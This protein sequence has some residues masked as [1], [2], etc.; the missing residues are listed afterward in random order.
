M[1]STWGGDGGDTINQEEFE[2]VG[3]DKAMEYCKRYCWCH[4]FGYRLKLEKVVKD[5]LSDLDAEDRYS[6]LINGRWIFE[7]ERG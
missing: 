6:D 4:G 7:V 3:F 5:F 1:L 2:R